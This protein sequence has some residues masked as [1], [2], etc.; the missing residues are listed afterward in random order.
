M[1]Q[2]F[3]LT[4]KMDL[5]DVGGVSADPPDPPLGTTLCVYVCILLSYLGLAV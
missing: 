3:V 1:S 5:L 2:F 4:K